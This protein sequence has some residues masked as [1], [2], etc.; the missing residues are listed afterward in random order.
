[1]RRLPIV[2]LVLAVTA[3]LLALAAPANAQ[4]DSDTDEPP[5]GTGPKVLV[6]KVSGLLDP[7]LADFIE[8][9]IATAEEDGALA[10][11]LQMNSSGSV[12][13]TDR[14][15]DLAETVRDATVPVYTWIG[16]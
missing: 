8:S 13:E 3:V 11:V 12:L 5:V 10:V 4:D 14:F 9:S 7:V 6:V 1:M 16:P 2:L 15:V